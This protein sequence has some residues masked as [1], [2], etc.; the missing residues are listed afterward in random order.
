MAD[1]GCKGTIVMI[2]DDM[3]LLKIIPLRLERA[4]YRVVTASDGKSGLA[5]VASE[6]PDVILLDVL[7]PGL[8]GHEVLKRLKA[9]DKTQAIPVILL[10][11]VTPGDEPERA[12]QSDEAF[13]VIKPYRPEDLL[14]KIELAMAGKTQFDS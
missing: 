14:K 1:T 10:T 2:E 8:D 3:S 6:Q 4:G 7:M 13:R 12:H 9:D 11:V 5:L